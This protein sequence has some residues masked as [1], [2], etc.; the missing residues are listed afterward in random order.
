MANL[1]CADLARRWGD[2][3]P[4]A[5]SQKPMAAWPV[6]HTAGNRMS[7]VGIGT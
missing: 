5:S 6:N 7:E 4:E 1:H 3:A 2:L